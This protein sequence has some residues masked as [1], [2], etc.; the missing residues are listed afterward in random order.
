MESKMIKKWLLLKICFIIGIV[1]FSIK[2]YATPL[3]NTPPLSA[4]ATILVSAA[5]DCTLG[6]NDILDYKDSLIQKFYDQNKDYNYFFKNVKNIFSMDDITVVNLETTLTNSIKKMNKQFTFKGPP[7]FTNIIKAGNIDAVNIANNHIHDYY[8]KGFNDTVHALKTSG[9]NY[10]GEGF[11][12]TKS[13]KGIKLGFL[14]YRGWVFNKYMEAQI[15]KDIKTLQQMHS[16]LIIVSFHWGDES[17]NYPND[18]Q[19][20]LGRFSIDN[21]ADLV[22]GHHP[23]VMEGIENYKGKY[24]VYSLGNFCFGGSRYVTDKDTFIFQQNFH[25]EN[26]KLLPDSLAYVI[27]CSI[28]SINSKNNFQPTP[29]TGNDRIRIIDRLNTYSKNY[30]V[31]VNQ[32]GELSR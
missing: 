10:F 1:A 7:E 28:S 21:G 15:K 12:L 32:S 30:G 17:K 22:L 3:E 26:S 31:I 8:E 2:C 23:H 24:I 4:K 6:N 29:S 5:G 13:I 25:F 14:G 20:K 18:I 16:Q 19:E 27:P 9:I 11:L